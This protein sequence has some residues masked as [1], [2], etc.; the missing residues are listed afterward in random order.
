MSGRGSEA[1]RCGR[2]GGILSDRRRTAHKDCKAG[3]KGRTAPP[4]GK[5]RIVAVTLYPVQIETLDRLAER[6]GGRSAAVQKLL[7][8]AKP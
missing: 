4:G 7:D 6:A 1:K 3:K 8:E 5:A 2:C